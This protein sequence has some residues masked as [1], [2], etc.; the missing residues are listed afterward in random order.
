MHLLA[1]IVAA[2]HP[3]AII[4]QRQC[5]ECHGDR[6]QGVADEYDDPL[7]GDRSIK[8]LAQLIE[9]TMPEQDESLC[10]GD[11]ATSV[12]E[13]IHGAFYSAEAQKR[14]GFGSDVRIEL[15]RR[16]VSQYRNA[17]ADLIG[18]L[19]PDYHRA[20]AVTGGLR[21]TYFSSDKMNKKHKHGLDRV[22]PVIDFDFKEGPPAENIDPR[23]FSIAWEG[24]LIAP[25]T[26]T[27]EFRVTTPN[28]VRLYINSDLREG[29]RNQRDDSSAPSRI[30]LIDGWVSSGK[31]VKTL[32]A[33]SEL[34]G[35]RRYPI[36]LD[37]F[38]YLEKS[39]SIKFEWKPPHGAWELLDGKHL[40]GDQASRT[41][42][43]TT[44]FPADDRSY[45][46]ERGTAISSEWDNATTK[47]AVEAANEVLDRIDKFA[48]TQKDDPARQKKL[49]DYA[50][51][52]AATAF[53]RPLGDLEKKLFIESQ[54]NNTKNPDTALKRCLLLALKSPR[55][56]YT[57][58][59]AKGA[60]QPD[61]Y[62]VASRLALTLWDSIPDAKLLEA[63]KKNQL[64]TPQQIESQARRMI[65]DP[66]TKEKLD[67]FF[68]HWLELE[69]RD[70]TKDEKMFPGFDAETVASLRHSLELFIDEVVWGENSD[71]RQ[72]LLANHLLLNGELAN[73]YGGDEK[74]AE[75]IPVNFDPKQRAGILTHPYL[76]SA[77]AYH[78]NTSP[79]HRGVFLTRNIVGRRLKPPPVAVAFKND[80]F[81]PSLTMR[82][83][84]TKLTRDTT[85]MSC[86]SVIN[87]LGFS[88]E[89]FDALG[90]WR[91]EDNKKPIDTK[92]AYVTL[93]GDTITLANARDIAEFAAK[94]PAAHR[95]FITALFHHSVKQPVAAYGTDTLETLRTEFVK[96]D[97]HIR[98]LLIRI[99]TLTATEP[100]R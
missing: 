74:S 33:R 50:E 22:D 52:F 85:C 93:D 99:A 66:R 98:E 70:L 46:Y 71:Y 15:S 91:T 27:Y 28:G 23:Q 67:G 94:S 39:A 78:N 6:G 16:T 81:D 64:Q 38:K 80:E 76:L 92:S 59:P 55:F 47:A 72:L 56:L 1:T 7:T 61:A 20:E 26:G 12:A 97:F 30:P 87:P 11:D 69:E 21:G 40:S 10:V 75:F 45:G 49:R 51:E 60:A 77:F 4:Y 29:D 82:E 95:A 96:S 73:L 2:E 36:R 88:L 8:S 3:G 90:R 34:L 24:S 83:K 41:F 53:R 89:S 57:E 86:H 44:R 32:S 9:R 100:I 48:K 17:V 14:L 84:V 79:I 19:D 63:T 13:F 65:S 54:F 58:L 31:E 43:V 35:G 42:V 68:E 18:S 5:A 25:S 62:Q 37:Y